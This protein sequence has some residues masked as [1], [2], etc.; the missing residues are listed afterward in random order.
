MAGL[1]DGRGP[2]NAAPRG[3]ARQRPAASASRRRARRDDLHW[4]LISG[5]AV[6]AAGLGFVGFRGYL[7]ATGGPMGSWDVAYL[8]VQLFVLE[9]GALEEG[10]A[11]PVSLQVARFLAPAV[12]A[13]A[14]V[15]VLVAVFREQAALLALRVTRGHVLVCGLGTKGWTLARSLH[16][17]RA[18]VVAV[19]RDLENDHVASA[20][21]AGITVV[22]GDATEPTTLRR[23]GVARAAAVVALCGASEVNAEVALVV[24]RERTDRRRPLDCLV[25]VDEPRLYELLRTRYVTAEHSDRFRVDAFNVFERGAQA[26][27]IRHPFF[28]EDTPGVG[29]DPPHLLVV[30]LGRLGRSVVVQAAR[31]WKALGPAAGDRCRVTVV[32]RAADARLA[33]LEVAHPELRQICDLVAHPIDVTS[34]A[35]EAEAILGTPDLPPPTIAYVCLGDEVLALRTGLLL[36]RWTSGHLPVV[37]RSR[38]E[39]GVAALLR[40]Q[41]ADSTYGR[42]HGFALLDRTCDAALLFGGTYEVLARALHLSYVRHRTAEGWRYGPDLDAERRTDPALAPWEE[43]A[44]ELRESNRSQAAHTGTKLAAVGCTLEELIDWERELLAFRDDE[45][46]RLAGLEH[47]RWV[48]ERVAAGWRLGPR[49]PAARRTPYLVGYE[50]LPEEVKEYDRAFVRELPRLL[51]KLGYRIVRDPDVDAPGTV[52]G[53]DRRSTPTTSAP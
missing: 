21:A 23:A 26:L 44:P 34:P 14:L 46:E 32:D 13:G 43:L 45:V 6:L 17:Q 51:A 30:G 10:D 37:V 28:G 8:T 16:A 40:Q 39:R 35:F 9:S 38:S 41:P 18:R 27:L 20:R 25:H 24:E 31:N 2:R 19:D 33:Q 11:I 1:G 49:D 52:G 29:S 3:R 5:A 36:H 12:G 50:T 47:E 7:H 53:A 22:I 4:W 15:T 42:L 48:E